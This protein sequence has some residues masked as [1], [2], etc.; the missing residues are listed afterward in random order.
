MKLFAFFVLLIITIVIIG[1]VLQCQND[2]DVF[3]AIWSQ[4]NHI[5]IVSQGR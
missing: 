4:F 2:S 3:T 5:M 1:I